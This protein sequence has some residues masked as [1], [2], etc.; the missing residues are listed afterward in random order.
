MKIS[1]YNF[2]SAIEDGTLIDVSD[3]A[4]KVG[5]PYPTFISSAFW[6]SVEISRMDC[7]VLL[8]LESLA[9]TLEGY[10]E[11]GITTY[12]VGYSPDL[13]K[14]GWPT[15][16]CP[17]VILTKIVAVKSDRFGY[18]VFVMIPDEELDFRVSRSASGSFYSM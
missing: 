11:R 14:R 12:E 15:A 16:A 13:K 17:W 9:S 8:T 1:Q 3:V 5:L 2:K 4:S 10:L 6:N 7:R 18:V